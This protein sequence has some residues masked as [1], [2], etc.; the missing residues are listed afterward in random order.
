MSDAFLI[1]DHRLLWRGS[2]ETVVVEPWGADS[3]R[4]RAV[5]G[6]PILDTE[7]ALLPPDPGSGAAA[8]VVVGQGVGNTEV[9]TLTNGAIRVVATAEMV[10]LPIML[11][12][13]SETD[14]KSVV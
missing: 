13:K 3:V 9:A 7:W 2:G 4:V 12:V 8:R 10:P 5:L 11:L 6:G 1:D 14:R